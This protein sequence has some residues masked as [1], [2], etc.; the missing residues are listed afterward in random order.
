[1][2]ISLGLVHCLDEQELSVKVSSLRAMAGWLS[3]C[4]AF[5]SI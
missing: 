3:F 5:A 2:V 4:N 1:M